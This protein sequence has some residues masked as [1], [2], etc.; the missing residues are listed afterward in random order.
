MAENDTE[1]VGLEGGDGIGGGATHASEAFR[2]FPLSIALADRFGTIMGP[3]PGNAGGGDATGTGGGLTGFVLAIPGFG[4]ADG[5]G[6]L[7]FCCVGVDGARLAFNSRRVGNSPADLEGV[8]AP[9]LGACSR[10]DVLADAGGVASVDG[11][12]V[13]SF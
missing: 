9:E 3:S 1:P 13:R 5:D 7:D 11:W 10:Q 12:R 2:F 4:T 8:G 6:T